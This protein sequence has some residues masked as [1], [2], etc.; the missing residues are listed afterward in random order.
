MTEVSHKVGRP[1]SGR[2]YPKD[3]RCEETGKKKVEDVV[4]LIKIKI[5]TLNCRAKIWINRET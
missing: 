5:F 4:D 3:V 1:Y 2:V